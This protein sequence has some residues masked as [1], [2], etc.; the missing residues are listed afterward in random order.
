MLSESGAL[1]SAALDVFEGR[2][3]AQFAVPEARQRASTTH[4]RLRYHRNRKAMEGS[5]VKISPRTSPARRSSRLSFEVRHESRRH[6]RRQGTFGSRIERLGSG[7]A[8]S[9]CRSKLAGSAG[10]TSTTI[11]WR[12]ARVRYASR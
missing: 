7:A 5:F 12:S 3:E 4:H 6:S 11:S 1:G 8:R 9:M 2:T 10:R